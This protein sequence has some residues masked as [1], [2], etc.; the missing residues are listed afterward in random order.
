MNRNFKV[1]NPLSV[2]RVWGRPQ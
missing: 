1:I 2:S